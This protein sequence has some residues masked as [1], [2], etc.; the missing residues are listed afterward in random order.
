MQ[1]SL[2]QWNPPPSRYVKIN[3]DAAIF[4]ETK[5][6]GMGNIVRDEYGRFLRVT[7]WQFAAFHPKEAEVLSLKEAISWI[8]GI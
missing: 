7:G 2:R 3:I 4:A 6:I 8:M 5:Q 1:S